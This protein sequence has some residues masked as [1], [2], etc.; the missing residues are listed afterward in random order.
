MADVDDTLGDLLREFYG[1]FGIP[2]EGPPRGLD[3]TA[4]LGANAVAEIE[5]SVLRTALSDSDARR[6]FEKCRALIEDLATRLAGEELLRELSRI[7]VP[8]NGIE[9]LSSGV[10]WFA[11]ASSLDFRQ[12]GLPVAPFDQI[13]LPVG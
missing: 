4:M 9:Q 8:P 1:T 3:V 12:E 7:P 10:F 11:L 6:Q 2:D 13:G 5:I